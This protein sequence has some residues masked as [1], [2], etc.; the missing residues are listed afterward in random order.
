MEIPGGTNH[1]QKKKPWKLSA[2]LSILPHDMTNG[3][4][5]PRKLRAASKV[6]AAG[7]LVA[8]LT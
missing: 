8:R 1:H 5:S 7:T 6:M 4:K 2:L 3:S